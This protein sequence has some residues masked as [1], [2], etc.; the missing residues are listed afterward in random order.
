MCPHRAKY[1]KLKASDEASLDEGQPGDECRT[2]A[3]QGQTTQ[4]KFG[5]PDGD[6]ERGIDY[7]QGRS[8]N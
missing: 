4:K 3:A 6:T 2:D 5:E 7:W 8:C 1:D